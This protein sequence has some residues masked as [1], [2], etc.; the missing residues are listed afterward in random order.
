MNA[1]KLKKK[2]FIVKICH[3]IIWAIFIFFI[4]YILYTGIANRV[5]GFTYLSIVAVAIEGVVLLLFKWK[6]PLTVIAYRYTE[7]RE[8]GFDIFLPKALAKYNKSIFTTIYIIGVI[9]VVYR[10]L[11]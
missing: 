2:L 10:I 9:F 7:D 1:L 11:Q 8:A 5:N 6:C 4:G 3:T